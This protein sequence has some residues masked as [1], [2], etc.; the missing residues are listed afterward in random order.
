[1][2]PVSVA[3]LT[4]PNSTRM[5]R[6][7]R[8]FG[9]EIATLAELPAEQVEALVL[10][11]DEA[12]TNAIQHAFEP[13]EQG[14]FTLVAELGPASLTLAVR[15]QGMP[16]DES[17]TPRFSLPD[18]GTPGELS[19]HG[20][21][22]Y[23]M[24]QAVDE[25]RWTGLGKQGKELRLTKHLRQ[26]D[27]TSRLSGPELLPYRADEP[28][29]PE[30]DYEIRRLRVEEAISVAQCVY[31]AYGY[32]YPNEDLYYPERI[33]GLNA[34]GDIVSGVAVTDGGEVVG[35]YALERTDRTRVAES[36]QAVVA[37]AHRDRHLMS[38]LR[39]FLEDEARRLGLLGIYGQPVTSHPFSQRVNESFGS[40]P[41]GVT[42]GALPGSFT[43]KK[44]GG[45]PRG[46]RETAMLYFKYLTPPAARVA[47]APR[48]HRQVLGRIYAHLQVPADLREPG[49][50]ASPLA[51]GQ[52]SVQYH[53]SL[54]LGAIRVL[55]VGADSAALVRRARRDLCDIGAAE[56]VSL[57]AMAVRKHGTPHDGGRGL[58]QLVRWASL[59]RSDLE[60]PGLPEPSFPDADP[61]WRRYSPALDTFDFLG[62]QQRDAL[63]LVRLREIVAHA[64]ARSPFYA[65]RLDGL[66]IESLGDLRRLPILGG[67]DLRCHV[68]PAGSG[69]LTDE[70]AGGYVFSS[71]GTAGKE[72]VVYRTAEEQHYNTL[73]LGKGFALSGF[74][75]GD[76]VANLFFAGSMWASFISVNMALEHAGCR[77]LPIGGNL[78]MAT[79]VDYLVQHRANAAI[80]LPSVLL[81]LAEHVEQH[82]AAGLRLRKVAMGGEHLFA[83]AR[84]YLRRTLGV[85]LFASAG[86]ATNDT[87]AIGYQCHHCESGVHHVHEDLH[88]V[89]ILDP[90]TLLP[91]AVGSAGK[92]VVTNLHRRLMPTIRYDVGDLGR[93]LAGDCPC[94]RKTRRMELLGR[95]DDVL[96]IGGGKI[97]P[98]L[99]AAAVHG[100]E[101]LSGHFQLVARMQG[102]LDQL[103]LRAERKPGVEGQP[104]GTHRPGAEASE[105]I[106]AEALRSHLYAASKEL[107]TMR[108]RGLIAEVAVEVLPAGGLPRSPRTGKIRLVVDERRR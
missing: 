83:G 61:H 74:G 71:G 12:C 81:S 91:A 46:Q 76:L 66:R 101:S 30:Q 13:G 103:L 23:L 78:E 86:Y 18:D 97:V 52:V 43:F 53:P 64:A 29:A 77:L 33:A 25:V 54:A 16:F 32:T 21:G 55:T 10:A 85:E 9:R 65:E 19:D 95:S 57:G 47:Y 104:G 22:F 84:E 107:R 100:V 2:K 102:N 106:L 24:R 45:Q 67:E 11:V 35:H 49:Q 60:S 6:L 48:Q 40:R 36:G 88:L 51:A 1:M 42:L 34:T 3:S 5:L 26:D 27:L 31:R 72:K 37:P 4:L 50:T 96:I 56:V 75:P 82:P 59:A 15:D 39:A 28:R 79:I 93:W 8:T 73:R 44:M 90:E 62:D 17:L 89:E 14:A 68:P 58:A 7:A 63:T 69:L 38:R 41:C 99:A 92:I 20:L 94:G 98:E 108:E 70:Q 105:A 87:G 80:T